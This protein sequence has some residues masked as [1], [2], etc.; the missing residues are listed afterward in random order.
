MF[1]GLTILLANLVPVMVFECFENT[2]SDINDIPNYVR[3]I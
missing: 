2:G 3:S 1:Q